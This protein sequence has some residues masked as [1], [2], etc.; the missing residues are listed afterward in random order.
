MTGTSSSQRVASGAL[1]PRIHAPVRLAILS[2]LLPAESMSFT[3]LRDA[4]RATDGNLS[5]HLTKL[6][7]A[8]YVAVGKQFVGKKP[9]TTVRLT[10]LGRDRFRLYLDALD[11]LLPRR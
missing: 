1:D 6:E 4:V 2:A 8:G 5:T 11:A 7:D 3:M 9:L 10:A